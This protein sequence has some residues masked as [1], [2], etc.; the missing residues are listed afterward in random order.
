MENCERM[1]KVMDEPLQ[2]QKT[3]L[4]RMNQIFEER[5]KEFR[6]RED[7]F[8]KK[9]KALSEKERMLK[10]QMEELKGRQSEYDDKHTALC[11]KEKEIQ[12]EIQ[13]LE[14]EKS[15][16]EE[17]K[18]QVE[19]RKE[20]VLMDVSMLKEELRNEILKNERIREEYESKIALLDPDMAELLS[21][22]AG[23]GDSGMITREEHDASIQAF[24][25]RIDG[26]K[27]ELEA[28]KSENEVLAQEKQRLLK[29]LFSRGNAGIGG[30]H[31]IKTEETEKEPSG[32]E[33]AVPERSPSGRENA[34]PERSPIERENAGE[35]SEELTASVLYNYLAK[36]EGRAE[37][38]KRHSGLAEQ[39]FMKRNGLAY[40]FVFAS[41]AYFDIRC[42]RKKD[43]YVKTAMEKF[44]N[45]QSG[46][47][48]AY[49]EAAGEVVATGYFTQEIT[50]SVLMDS[51][52]SIVKRC[53]NEEGL[54]E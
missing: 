44:N 47:K 46:V 4:E 11:A 33:H 23:A 35:A 48:F 53:F 40:C 41:P 29:Q 43:R 37:V 36:N 26:M 2:T 49:D 28:L 31:E 27:K 6:L 9:Q 45:E 12:S 16:L 22:G 7:N 24:E 51:V 21:A 50:A 20:Q 25:S 3:A 42:K 1:G 34:V 17:M 14:G 18:N 39:I 52:N 13:K 5:E 32:E 54:D 38:E 10:V 19:A 8:N 15:R 30:G